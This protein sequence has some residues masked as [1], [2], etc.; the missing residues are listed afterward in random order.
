MRVRF[1]EV[2]KR[3]GPPKTRREIDLDVEASECVVI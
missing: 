1:E 2:G 3:F